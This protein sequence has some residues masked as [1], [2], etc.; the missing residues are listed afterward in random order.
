MS[1]VISIIW[2]LLAI[3]LVVVVLLLVVAY[4]SFFERKVIGYMQDRVGPNRVGP[5]GNMTFA[6]N[7]S[8]NKHATTT[9]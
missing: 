8:N 5:F 1:E 6:E 7:T 2:T 9:V 4:L 3:I